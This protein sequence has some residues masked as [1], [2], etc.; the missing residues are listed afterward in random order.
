MQLYHDAMVLMPTAPSMIDARNSILAADLARFGGANQSEL[1]YAFSTRG[2]G[3]SAFAANGEDVQP[4]PAFDSPQQGEETVRFR[5]FARDEGNAPINANVYVGHYEARVSPI[6][7]T[8][9]ATGPADGSV[10]VDASNLDNAA[11]FRPRTY[12]LVAHAP[13][14]GHLR[15]RATFRAGKSRTIDLYFAT[16]WASRN[17]G[18]VATGDGTRLPDLIDDTEVSN[19]HAGGA[20]VEGRRVTVQLAG[21]AH[22]LRQSQVSAYLTL[23]NQPSEIPPPPPAP[24]TQNRFTALRAFVVRACLAGADAANPTCAGTSD[25]GWHVVLPELA[26]LLPGRHSAAGRPGAPPARVRPEWERGLASR[27]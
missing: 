9:P 7:D 26:G 1:W 21:G 4:R 22:K 25:A 23:E 15:F 8:N 5:A 3:F 19:W 18:A 17:K 13:G 27:P 6:A 16:N 2:F 11:S 20:P 14:Y 12:E 10:A 24:G